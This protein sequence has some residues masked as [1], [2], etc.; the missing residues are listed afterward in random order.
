MRLD[1]L[2]LFTL[3][4]ATVGAA[5]PIEQTLEARGKCSQY[6][7]GTCPKVSR[8]KLWS[9]GWKHGFVLQTVQS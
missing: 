2:S 9:P 5:N 3:A 6:T 4:L 8:T 7:P 1:L